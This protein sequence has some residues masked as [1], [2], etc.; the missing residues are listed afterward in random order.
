MSRQQQ[1]ALVGVA[2]LVLGII[3]IV[4]A[5]IPMFGITQLVAIVLGII[6]LIL[7]IVGRKQASEQG[8]PT[9]TATAGI[10][11]GIITAVLSA[12][13]YASCMYCVKKVG[14]GMQ[15]VG[16]EFKKQLGSEE[17]RREFRNAV[18]KARKEREQADEDLKKLKKTAP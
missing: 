10:V 4:F 12:L 9:G 15:K 17:F 11:L 13:I 6:A 2:A 14:D 3:G 16:A 7:G 1:E 18:E 8:L 5:I